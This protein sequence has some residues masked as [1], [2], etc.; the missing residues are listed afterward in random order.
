MLKKCISISLVI[1]FLGTALPAFA[2]DMV[3]PKVLPAKP[4]R[5]GLLHGSI[6]FAPPR[7]G[8]Q[9]P[10]QPPQSQQKHLTTTGKILKWVGIGLMGEGALTMG[11]GAATASSECNGLGASCT[12]TLK[13]VYYG[14]GGASI[15]VGAVLLVI[16][17]HKKE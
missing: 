15:G 11:L 2:G 6:A 5:F 9:T 1:A 3:D 10:N 8:E 17:L 13:N 14:I 16:G 4:A 7:T 12:G